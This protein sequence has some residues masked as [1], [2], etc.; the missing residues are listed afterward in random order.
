LRSPLLDGVRQL[1]RQQPAPRRRVRPISLS[2]EEDVLATG[3]GERIQL[4]RRFCCSRIGVHP[5]PAEVVPEPAL[6]HGARIRIEGLT[7]G[8]ERAMH[9]RGHC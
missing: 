8:L 3:E 9:R 6:H 4:A 5:H 7:G 2:A 1:V